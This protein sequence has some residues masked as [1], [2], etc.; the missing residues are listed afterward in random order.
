MEKQKAQVNKDNMTIVLKGMSLRSSKA[1]YDKHMSYDDVVF[2]RHS[3]VILTLLLRLIE[4]EE[5]FNKMLEVQKSNIR[6][7]S[8][9]YG[10]YL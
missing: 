7:L 8:K 3:R 2:F 5:D 1:I 9:K 6:K 10:K 4:N